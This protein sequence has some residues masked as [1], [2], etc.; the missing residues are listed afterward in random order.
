[1]GAIAGSPFVNDA[2]EAQVSVSYGSDLRVVSVPRGAILGT[3]IADTGLP[4]EQ[5]CAGRGTCHKCKVIAQGA[6]SPLDEQEMDALAEPERKANYRLA[7]RAHVLAD[8]TVI[9]APILVYSNKIFRA[10]DDYKQPDTPLGLAIDLGSTTVAAYIVALSSQRVC[11][12]AAALNQQTAFG[13]DVISR[14]AAAMLGPD[15]AEQLS[16]LARTSIVQAVQA[17]RLPRSSR[18]R[19][20][21]VTIV[22]NCAMHHLLLRLP[23]ETLARLP[24]QPYSTAPLRTRGGLFGDTFPPNAEVAL[25]PLIGGFVGSDAL[26]CLAYYGFDTAS[27]PLAAIDLGT[28]GEVMLTDGRRILVASTAAGPAFEGV[29]ISCGTRAVDGAI[30]GIRANPDD[31]TLELVTIGDLPPVGLTGSGLLDLVLGLR[32]AGVI[33]ASGRFSRDSSSFGRRF[34]RDGRGVR[35]FLITDQAVDRH[36]VEDEAGGQRAALY[37]TQQ[38]IRELQKAKAAIR[39]AIEILMARLGLQAGDLQRVILTGSFGSQLSAEAIV[40]LGLIPPVD[41]RRVES[42]ANG[43]GFGAALFLCDDGF[44]RGERLATRAE[45][46]DLDLDPQF[47]QRYVEA[48]ELCSDTVG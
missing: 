13:A 16:L 26:A 37:L 11:A 23:V 47:N 32:R 1:M 10:C 7:C 30:T 42:S 48:T 34:S 8:C 21:K 18:E 35:R 46:I 31:G 3:A 45:Q 5:P 25:P 12:G 17:L 39:T 20:V 44:A 43:A 19:I 28:N 2:S 29:S 14:L 41:L 24:F 4:L 27:E 38:D 15:E 40:G 6:L 33:D 36:G 22:G 9:L